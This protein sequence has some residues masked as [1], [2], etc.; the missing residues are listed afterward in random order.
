MGSYIYNLV[1]EGLR[2]IIR[3]KWS[4][5]KHDIIAGLWAVLIFVIVGLINWIP[6]GHVE[7]PQQ[8]ALSL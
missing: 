4:K 7:L 5:Y 3:E 2:L 8:E 1:I 6:Y